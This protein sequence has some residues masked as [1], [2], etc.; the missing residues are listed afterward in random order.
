VARNNMRLICSITVLL[1]VLF[2][3]SCNNS[4][5]ETMTAMFPWQIE[6]LPSGNSRVFSIELDHS[7]LQQAAEV[8]GQRYKLGL[9]FNQDGS[10]TLEV[11]YSEVT[12]AS[13]SAKIILTLDISQKDAMEIRQRA[14]ARQVLGSGAEKFSLAPQ[15]AIQAKQRVVSAISY[16]PYIDLDEA[17]VTARF[18]KPQQRIENSA[19][20]VHFLYPD[21][22][23]DLLFDNDGKELL[24]YVSP[25]HFSRLNK[26]LQ[27]QPVTD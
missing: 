14:V 19:G 27:Q 23:L 20:K 8:L 16:I 13:L 21:K 2:L 11:F 24:Q 6:R 25:R 5:R 1:P 7:T 22:G 10:A 15:D 26:L 9:F 4:E 17:L 3:L 12:L 18:G